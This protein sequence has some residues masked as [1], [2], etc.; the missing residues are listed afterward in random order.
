[1]LGRWLAVVMSSVMGTVVACGGQS[2]HH[3]GDDGGASGRGGTT[4][5]A[6]RGGTSA[7]RGGTGAGGTNAGR[8]GTGAGGTSAGSSGIDGAGRANR[9]GAGGQS[10]GGAAGGGAAGGGAA[11][12]GA[13]G[14]G[15]A[16]GSGGMADRCATPTFRS[17]EGRPFFFH[18]AETGECV[19]AGLTECA[20]PEGFSSLAECLMACPG[21]KPALDACDDTLECSVLDPGCCGHCDPVA[22][23]DLTAVNVQR[24][25]DARGCPG[26]VACGACPDVPE[27]ERT[28]QYFYAECKSHRCQ[29]MDVRTTDAVDCGDG[30]ACRLRAGAGCCEGCTGLGLVALSST[31][32]LKEMCQHVG[33]DDCAPS[34]PAAFEA[35]CSDNGACIVVEAGAGSSNGGAPN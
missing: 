3:A 33:C 10:M 30:Q 29:L 25:D 15:N 32:Y 26:G 9:A 28:R 24:I 13:A 31:E 17:C 20:T 22:A 19:A 5:G 12:G 21:S 6:A 1:M 23:Q 34:L 35:A 27:L 11:G 18:D 2:Q 7:G 8:G 4:G 14:G 16:A